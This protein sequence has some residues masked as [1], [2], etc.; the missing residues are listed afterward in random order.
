MG[1]SI[2]TPSGLRLVGPMLFSAYDFCSRPYF[3]KASN[4]CQ[5]EWFLRLCRYGFGEDIRKTPTGTVDCSVL[6]GGSDPGTL[7]AR[8]ACTPVGSL[9]SASSGGSDCS[10]EGAAHFLFVAGAAAVAGGAALPGRYTI[11]TC[12]PSSKRRSFR[13]R[14]NFPRPR[15]RGTRMAGGADSFCAGV[16]GGGDRQCFL[17]GIGEGVGQCPGGGGAGWIR[18]AVGIAG[19]AAEAAGAAQSRR[20]RLSRFSGF[21]AHSRDT[22]LAPPRPGGGGGGAAG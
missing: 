17:P 5:L 18:G 13:H 11:V 1:A 9:L 16:R 4:A 14:G 21:T 20:L 3:P 19:P 15:S 8:S 7:C 22:V 10:V 2:K 6:W 12:E